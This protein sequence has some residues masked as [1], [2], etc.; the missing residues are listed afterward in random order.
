MVMVMMVMVM[1]M[2]VMLMMVL[3]AHDE[4]ASSLEVSSKPQ[5]KRST[6]LCPTK[7]L[8]SVPNPSEALTSAPQRCW[9]RPLM[10]VAETKA[11]PVT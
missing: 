4:F 1:L 10:A 8:A 3:L 5:L 2:L 6:D 7:V 11:V 9:L